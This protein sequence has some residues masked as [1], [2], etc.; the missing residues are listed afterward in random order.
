MNHVGGGGKVGG[1]GPR[2]ALVR[3]CLDRSFYVVK[4]FYFFVLTCWVCRIRS[5]DY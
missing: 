1:I 2:K 4:G 3:A 5:S